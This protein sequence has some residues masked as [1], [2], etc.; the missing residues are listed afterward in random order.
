MFI[1]KNAFKSITRSKVRNILI[2]IIVAVIAIA[3]CVSLSIKSAAAKAEQETLSNLS[4]TAQISLDRDKIFAE[5]KSSDASDSSTDVQ[6]LMKSY[7]D[8][9]LTEL[10]KYAKSTSVK[11]FYYT[12]TSSIDSG[13]SLEAVSTNSNNDSSASGGSNNAS[14]SSNIK[15]DIPA[16][17][18]SQGDFTIVGYSSQNAMTDFVNGTSKI[19]SGTIFSETTSDK[20]CIVSKELATLNSLEVGDK[21]VVANPNDSTETYT[22]KIDGIYTTTN[23]TSTNSGGMNFSTGN[24]SA[25]QIYTSYNTL[26]AIAAKSTSVASTE[27][28][29]STDTTSTT[30][31]RTQVSGT[32]VLSDVDSYT[33]FKADVTKLGLSDYYAVSSTDLTSYEQSVLPLQN[34]SNFALYLLLIVLGIGGI[35]LVVFNFF[36]IRER[37]FEIG[38]LTAIGMKKSKVATQFITELFIVTFIAILIGTAAGA[39]ISVPTANKLLATQISAQET[40]ATQTQENFGKPGETTTQ[41]GSSDNSSSS[42]GAT[43]ASAPTN[44]G[45][46][47]TAYISTINATIN[48]KVIGE[49]LG[50]GL[51]L[52][53]F[54]SCVAVVAILRYEPLKILSDRT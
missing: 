37:K 26:A 17:M 39:A 53:L 48:F 6:T 16:G 14:D 46:K 52:T 51:L 35:I 7:P 25:N 27:T 15:R 54:S 13:G 2:G 24:D 36:N 30:A 8:L 23:S 41:K 21:I 29:S 38:V 49:L 18:G 43:K 10:Q 12:L 33:A 31:L 4:V 22:L 20:V 28:D 32:Y 42:S 19:T 47:A 40:Q 3:C 34:L 45:S 50:I 1:F 11:D 44:F 9:T 5:S